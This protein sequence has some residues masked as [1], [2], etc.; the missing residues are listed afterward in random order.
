MKTQQYDYDVM[1]IGAGHG[2]DGA[3]MLNKHGY[4]VA[5]IEA[6]KVGGTCTNWACNAKIVLDGPVKLSR[7]HEQLKDIVQ[8]DLRLSWEQNMA[9]K[10]EVIDP[11]ADGMEKKFTG[12]GIDVLHGWAKFVDNHT[13]EIDGKTYTSDKFVIA[14]GLHPHQLDV[15]GKEYAHDSKDFLDLNPL[16]KRMTVIGSGYI[17]MEFATIANA[18]GSE[19]TVLMRGDRVL[20]Q[21]NAEY[22]DEV[23]QD[24]T[25]RGVK[26]I[27][28]ATVSEFTQENNHYIVHYDD[29][30]T[31]ET[32]WILDATGRVPNT[33]GYGLDELGIHYS[34]K[35]IQVNGKMQTNIDN[36]FVAGD[37]A[38]TTYPKLTPTAT[39]HSNY[40]AHFIMGDTKDDMKPFVVPTVTFTS[41][42]IAEAGVTVAEAKADREK[43]DILES[44]VTGDWFR[45]VNEDK[46]GKQT[47]V[48]DKAGH[49]VGATE[50]SEEAENF[51]NAVLPAIALKLERDQ[52]E[53]I[54]PLFPSIMHEGW[55]KL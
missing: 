33:S 30:K 25:E 32:D 38:D 52:I 21:F 50:V 5:K 3:V 55:K 4:K 17:G 26:F 45:K 44:D 51:I 29:G 19:V 31:V 34:D 13:V 28:N 53:Q 6:E 49:L 15:P 22:V 37:V 14:T 8:G 16:P 27:K 23:V 24:M 42:R 46:I 39:H 1:F 18:F 41:P 9:H 12:S 48:F 43:Y 47:L 54:V 10:H 40:I 35:G 2:S 7:T 11:L 36:I 20:R